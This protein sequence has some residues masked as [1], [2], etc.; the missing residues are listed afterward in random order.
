MELQQLQKGK[1]YRVTVVT[2]D[3]MKDVR[4]KETTYER[5]NLTLQA[6]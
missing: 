2:L 4:Y 1:N 3:R 6:C 5:E